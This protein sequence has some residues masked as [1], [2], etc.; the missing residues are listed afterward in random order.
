MGIRSNSQDIFENNKTTLKETSKDNS[1]KELSYMT[2]S[3]LEV[4]D[5]DG[6]KSEYIRGM[7]LI[8]TP[9]SSDALYSGNDDNV[10]LI[11]FKNGIMDNKTVYNVQEK[12]YTSLLIYTDIV[13]EWISECRTKLNYILVYNEKKNTSKIEGDGSKQEVQDTAKRRIGKYFTQKA[14]GNFI[15]F[16]LEKFE[17]I[18][19]KNVYTYNEKEFQEKFVDVYE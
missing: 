14:K 6:V 19:F 3:Q 17:G 9:C 10:Y 1:N 8:D 5:F 4:V 18:Y 16:G 7:R 15:A 11:E 2:N 12:I 13:G